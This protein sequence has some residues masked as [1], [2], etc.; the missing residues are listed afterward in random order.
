M[1][2]N[3]NDVNR[4]LEAIQAENQRLQRA[5]EELSILNELSVVIGSVLN[6]TRVMEVVVKRSLQAV[7]AEQGVITMFDQEAVNPMKTL[8]RAADTS[9]SHERFHLDQN[10]A[11]W[12]HLNKKALLANDV[13]NDPRFSG[14]RIAANIRSI[15]C[16]PL[17]VK[18]RLI[19]VL[20]VFNKKRAAGFDDNDE[21]LL[22]IIATQS[23]QV[24]ENARLYETEKAKQDMDRELSAAWEVQRSLLPQRLPEIPGIDLAA[25]ST[26]AKEVGGDYFDVFR[27]DAQRYCILLAD[28]SGKGLP[29]A[30]VS[31]M[32]KGIFWA[33]I[34]RYTSTQEM[35]QATNV[36]L[37]SIL[38]RMTFVTAMLAMLDTK[39]RTVELCSAGQC[40]PL[41]MGAQRAPEYLKMAGHPMN[42]LE[43][44]SFDGLTI[45]LRAGE[46]LM[47]YSD[48]VIEA[49]N[50]LD[51]FYGAP[52]LLTFAEALRKKRAQEV[53]DAIVNS[54]KEFTG[55]RHSADD[56]TLVVIRAT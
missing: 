11:G 13:R 41:Y 39:A 38:P 21:R 12:M 15:L 1:A 3:D 6:S 27:L 43:E 4:R 37:R 9:T 45:Q 46:T 25:S 54:V 55:K 19:G 23:A 14:I 34:P 18:N 35:L 29:A 24:I 56:V 48:G 26:P 36:L 33:Q 7:N 5:V 31:T 50:E 22:S 2:K 20:S 47:L 8:I 49:Q 28:V 51:N 42:W 32:V 10:V 52:A 44:P 16:A 53:H 40:P 30:L 17:L